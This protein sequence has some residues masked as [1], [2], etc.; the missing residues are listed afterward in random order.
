MVDVYKFPL[1]KAAIQSLPAED[2][3]TFILGGHALNQLGMWLRLITLSTNESGIHPIAERL[4]ASQ[5]HM[6]LRSLYSC[7]YETWKWLNF[8]QN[9][10]ESFYIPKCKPEAVAAYDEIRQTFK[11]S[12][13]LGKIRNQY[14]SHFPTRQQVEDAFEYA[15]SSEDWS[16]YMCNEL[17]NS[18]WCSSEVVI[19]YGAIRL[20]GVD[21]AE[22]GFQMILSQAMNLTN[23]FQDFI[24]AIL[25]VIRETYTGI[26]TGPEAIYE[27]SGCP[28]G[29]DFELPFLLE[30]PFGAKR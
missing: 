24:T 13:I 28:S 10:V 20:A 22:A 29:Q 16:W 30:P 15:P 1:S 17:T 27:F 9:H 8:D 19:G 18:F 3:R 7:L 14:S 11:E 12:G 26:A 4:R 21:D 2:R 5:S 25:I 23:K 6:L